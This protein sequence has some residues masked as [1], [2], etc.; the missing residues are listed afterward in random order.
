MRQTILHTLRLDNHKSLYLFT[1]ILLFGFTANAQHA[2][3][4]YEEAI[5][6]GNNLY[7]KSELI[8]AKAYYQQALK[9][10]PNDDYA[11]SKIT[12]IVKKMKSSMAA[13]DE[14]YDIVDVADALYDKS[15]MDKALVE[16]QKALKIIP[17]DE[18][19]LKK[20]RE[21][22][23][24]RK[25][26][27]DKIV[28]FNKAI[29]AGKVYADDG[30]YDNAIAEFTDAASIFP[31]NDVPISELNRVNNLKSD[32]EQ[33]Q[34]LFNQKMNEASKYLLIKN[35]VKALSLYNEANKI[36]PESDAADKKITEISDL[37]DIQKKYNIQVEKADAY[38][39]SKDFISARKQY[40]VAANLWSEKNY[41]N[42]MISKIDEKLAEDRKD[43]DNNY[44]LYVNLGDS[45]LEI[46]EYSQALSEFNLAQNL[47]P[48]EAYPKAKLA[49]INTIF[50]NRKKA[51]EANYSTMITNADSAFDAALY[52]IARGK[53]ET[54]LK[55]KPGD[56]Y[57]QSQLQKIDN[58][59][60]DIAAKG[61]K[62]K[63][64]NDIIAQ[65]DKL[66]ASGNLD[67][68]IKKYREAQALKSIESYPQIKI[69]A[70]K[71]VMA[72]AAKQKQLDD[73]Y[74]ELIILAIRQ[75]NQ[76]NLSIARSS[77]ANASDLK[78]DEKMPQKRITTIDSLIS[79]NK[80]LAKIKKQYD[81]LIAG[82]DSLVNSKEYS[83]A[84]LKYDA[85]LA[86]VPNDEVAVQKKAKV[87]TIQ[88]N[89][90]KEADRKKAYEDAVAKGDEFFANGSFELARVEFNKATTIKSNE[91]Y[92]KKRLRDINVALVKLA[93][94]KEQRYK[95]SITAADN[96]FEQQ[97]YDDAVIKYQLA[98]SI[99]PDNEYPQQKIAEC[100]GFLAE[101]LKKL[102]A[103]YNVAIANADKLYAA[104]I[105]DKAITAFKK[106]E[107]IKPDETYPEEMIQRISSYIKEN[108]IVDVIG[109]LTTIPADTTEKF[110]FEPVKINVRKS[111]YIFIRA[112]SPSAKA[113]KL[114]F[115]YGSDKSKNG[116]FVVQINKDEAFNDYIVRVGNQYKWFADD[117]NWIT[118][119]PE[120]DSVEIK[121]LR[122]SKGY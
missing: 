76:G 110:T 98:S 4:T 47:K 60:Q 6:K 72:N 48:G 92:P 120:N 18:Y 28:A 117:N 33:R 103:E 115:S 21:I 57:P 13:E 5:L 77:F 1:F 85:A 106:A 69:D 44:K 41:P 87:K 55:V 102:K 10:K 100:N 32:F 84:I 56:D 71:K 73:K 43:I 45:L 96:F 64:Y 46:K 95:E 81:L 75:F 112:K 8:N 116:G 29:E 91:E 93:A 9:I 107:T 118:I 2:S 78:P 109:S 25:D 94:E 70:I 62:D 37:A 19:T 59:L 38:Y 90:K 82:G 50:E 16:Y 83:S 79:V 24:F 30:D 17:D 3:I 97:N 88:I 61:K 113:V 34:A 7:N 42:D 68:S 86:L 27:K 14:F 49:E 23:A 63:E 114:I 105:Y 26:K 67:L 52:N 108:S 99:K 121:M 54:A 58:I 101:K 74:N 11:K 36:L 15:E 66:F 20:V 39:I 22:T 111:N 51:F 35:Y 31:D 65:A 89:I 122:I 12:D 119:Y 53:Y 80:N 40:E 104:K